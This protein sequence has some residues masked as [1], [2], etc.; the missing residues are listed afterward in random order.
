M[1]AIS[2]ALDAAATVEVV[3]PGIVARCRSIHAATP[4]SAATSAAPITQRDAPANA[5][6]AVL[7]PRGG[8]AGGGAVPAGAERIEGD[9]GAVVAPCGVDSV[10]VDALTSARRAFAALAST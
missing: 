7:A 3:P 8:G 9:A 10:T 2:T 6:L 1:A 4:T 5:A